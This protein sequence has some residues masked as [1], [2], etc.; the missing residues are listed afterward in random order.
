MEQEYGYGDSVY[1]GSDLYPLH[2]KA[3]ILGLCKDNHPNN[4]WY[5]VDISGLAMMSSYP[6]NRITPRR[7]VLLEKIKS[8]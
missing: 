1:C 6:V 3:I 4:P 2:F 8:F 7:T 5:N